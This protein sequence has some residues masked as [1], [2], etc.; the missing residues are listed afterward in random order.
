[1]RTRI[2][3][4]L[5]VLAGILL[6]GGASTRAVDTPLR[7]GLMPYAPAEVLLDRFG[8]MERYLERTLSRPV[9]LVGAQDYRAFLNNMAGQAYDLVFIA[10]HIGMLALRQGGWL[11]L[12]R[13]RQPVNTLVVVLDSSPLH[14]FDDLRDR[15][16]ATPDP[17]A[18]V[19][20]LAEDLIHERGMA[21]SVRVLHTASH[22]SALEMTLHGLADAAVTAELQLTN[23]P[24]QERDRLRILY[25][26]PT[27]FE[28]TYLVSDRLPAALRER[29]T[30]LLLQFADSPEA[31]GFKDAEMTRLEAAELQAF[32]PLEPKLRDRLAT[33][34]SR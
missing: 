29:L 33:E 6:W 20:L 1:M 15:K 7:L 16:L 17:L 34:G 18:L 2:W 22:L 8:P 25:T 31:V 21:E 4:C 9:E 12:V 14:R 13:A 24:Q 26:L 10:P 3:T 28:L 19:T 23:L 27:T 5:G 30:G 11:P 32:S